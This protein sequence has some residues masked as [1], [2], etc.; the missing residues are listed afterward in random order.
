MNK[1]VTCMWRNLEH[2]TLSTLRR[3]GTRN[4]AGAW[5][6]AHRLGLFLEA[7]RLFCH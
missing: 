6:D 5:G 2:V 7:N 4:A 3:R 1:L